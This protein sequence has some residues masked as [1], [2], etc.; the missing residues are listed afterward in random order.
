VQTFAGN[1]ISTLARLTLDSNVFGLA[2]TIISNPAELRGVPL[3]ATSLVLTRAPLGPRVQAVFGYGGYVDRFA[4]IPIAA[5]GAGAVAG[6]LIERAS[7]LKLLYDTGTFLA[8]GMACS[9]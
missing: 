1:D 6:T 8:A 5:T 2:Q 7:G 4:R 3:N 9:F